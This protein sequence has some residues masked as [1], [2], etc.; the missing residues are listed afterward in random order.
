MAK[1]NLHSGGF[2]LCAC[3][4]GTLF[5]ANFRRPAVFFAVLAFQE[6]RRSAHRGNYRQGGGKNG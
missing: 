6:D 4:R 5:L 1:S 2:P 3:V